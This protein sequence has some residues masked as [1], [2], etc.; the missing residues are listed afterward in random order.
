MHAPPVFV[1][2]AP[3]SGTTL[4]R[5]LLN[6]HP[7]L[8]LTFEAS[9]FN[10]ARAVPRGMDAAEFRRA[11]VQ[12]LP[13]AWQRVAPG[14]LARAAPEGLPA[15]DPRYLTALMAHCAQRLGKSRWGDKSPTHVYEVGALLEAFP[16]ARVVHIVRDP[17][18]VVRSLHS[19]PWAGV[20]LFGNTVTVRLALD[21]VRPFR[22]RIH[23]VR[24]EDL[25]AEPEATLRSILAF[26]DL[27]WSSQVLDA[28]AHAPADA[29]PVP[30]LRTRSAD[31]AALPARVEL[32][33]ADAYRI[34]RITAPQRARYGY[35]PLA[36]VPRTLGGHFRR[37][38]RDIVELA[39]VGRQLLQLRR[40]LKAR[41]RPSAV[42]V[43]DAV[44]ALHPEAT[45]ACTPA[46]RAHLVEWLCT[47]ATAG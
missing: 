46:E 16:G 33:P 8:H 37:A 38:W 1:V 47:P 5:R 6:A 15:R 24:L 32:H 4:L 18:A 25:L 40:V 21:A 9:F 31:R 45:L 22:S 41:P 17:V 10:L 42:A 14:A 7:D 19:V 23:E 27:P 3:R 26:C 43:F 11:W 39:Q 29:P 34:S 28:D 20:N 44:N 2:G 36:T 35:P 13:F 30:W 12:S